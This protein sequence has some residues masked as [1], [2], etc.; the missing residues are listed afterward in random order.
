MREAV[1]PP[2]KTKAQ[3]MEE[4]ADA[5]RKKYPLDPEAALLYV[6]NYFTAVDLVEILKEVK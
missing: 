2:A 6:L 4:V 5:L 1:K 3:L